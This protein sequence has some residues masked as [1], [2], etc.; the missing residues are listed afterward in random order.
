MKNTSQIE[1]IHMRPGISPSSPFPLYDL[2]EYLFQDLCRDLFDCEFGI[3]FCDVYGVRGQAQDGIDLIA[4]RKKA[5]EIEVGQCKCHKKFT[6]KQVKKASDEFFYHWKRWS[7]EG[8]KRFI[9]F[10]SCDLNDRECHDQILKEKKRFAEFGISYEA[11]SSSK[12][13]GKLGPHPAIVKR[14]FT[15][16]PDYWVSIICGIAPPAPPSSILSTQQASLILSAT[17]AQSERL[18]TALSTSAEKEI[19]RLREAWREGTKQEAS[20]WVNSI[21]NDSQVWMA[22]SENVR[23]KLLLFEA[24]LVLDEYGDLVQAKLLTEKARVLAPS[25]D[26]TRVLA[27]ITHRESGPKAAL[28]ILLG[29]DDLDSRNLKAAFLLEGGEIAQARSVLDAG[30]D[31]KPNAEAYR[32]RALS[33]VLLKDMVQARLEIQKALEIAPKWKGV[34]IAAGMI[35]Y[36]SALSPAIM[37]GGAVRW[38]EPVDWSFVKRDDASLLLL[39]DGEQFFRQLIKEAGD[40]EERRDFECWRLACFANDPDR[41]DDAIKFCRDILSRDKTHYRVISWAISRKYDVKLGPSEKRLKRLVDDNEAEIPHILSLV[42]IYLTS[43]PRRSPKAIKLLRDSESLFKKHKADHVWLFWFCQ[44]LVV[45]NDPSAAVEAIVGHEPGLAIYNIKAMALRSIALK[46][47]DF[48]P[49][50]DHLKNAYAKTDDPV[51]LH[52]SCELM[53]HLGDW[54]F[55]ADRA[56]ELA[57]RVQTTDA[58][59]LAG[60]SAYNAKRFHLC[61]RLLDNNRRLYSGNRLPSELRRVRANCCRAIGIIPEAIAEAESLA[62]EEPTTENLLDL[63]Y[64][65]S[66]KGD[67]KSLSIVARRILDRPD[68]KQEESLRLSYLVKWEDEALAIAL[69]RLATHLGIPDELV[70]AATDIGFQLGLDAELGPLSERMAFLGREGK[71]GIQFATIEDMISLVEKQREQSGKLNE[72]YR[73]GTAP[74]HVI[75]AQLNRPLVDY[76]HF[77]P[78][79]NQSSPDPA[80][81][82]SLM[83]RH[84]GRQIGEELPLV[85]GKSRICM[86]ITAVLLSM[87]LKILEQVERH[88]RPIAIPAEMVPALMDMREK[89][90]HH[91][92]KRLEACQQ[93]V[94]M[95][96]TGQIEALE[97]PLSNENQSLVKELGLEWLAIFEYARSKQGYLVDFYPVQKRG[98]IG[99]PASIPESVNEYVTNCRVLIES[100]RVEGPLSTEEH[101][102]ALSA[103]G[104]QGGIDI[105][106]GKIPKQGSLLILRANIPEIL[107]GANLL[108]TISSRFNVVV[109]KREFE[110]AKQEL[111]DNRKRSS[112]VNWLGALTDRLSHGIGEGTFDVLP[113]EPH[114]LLKESVEIMSVAFGCLRSLMRFS[115]KEDDIIWSDDRFINGYFRRDA[116]PIVGINEILQELRRKEVISSE[117]YYGLLLKLR[118][119]NARFIPVSKDEILHHLSHAVIRDGLVVETRALNILRRYIAACLHGGSM[120]QRPP[121]AEG[122]SNKTGELAFVLDLV[123]NVNDSVIES[124]KSRE[125]HE[126]ACRAKADWILDNLYFDHLGAIK[127]I[128]VHRAQEDE[129]YVVALGLVGL[130]SHAIGLSS[131][132]NLEARRNY[133]GWLSVRILKKRFDADPDLVIGVAECL[134][135]LIQE[136]RESAEK[137]GPPHVVA[138]LLQLY[139]DDLPHVIKDELAKDSAFMAAMDIRIIKINE[140]GGLKFNADEFWRH[141]SDVI[142]GRTGILSTVDSKL[143]VTFQPEEGVEE[144]GEFHFADPATG[145]KKAVKEALFSIMS[146]SPRVREMTLRKNKEWFDCPAE[147]FERA[148]GVIVTTSDVVQRIEETLHW[149][150]SSARVYYGKVRQRAAEHHEFK[151][152]EGLPP[153]GEGLLRHFRLHADLRPDVAFGEVIADAAH[154]LLHECGLLEAIDRLFGFPVALPAIMIDGVADLTLEEMHPAVVKLIRVAQ[155]PI[156]QIHLVHTLVRL[157]DKIPACRRIARQVA[158]NLLS[159]QGVEECEAFRALLRWTNDEFGY[160]HDARQWPAPVRLAMVWAHSHRLYCIFKSAGAPVSWIQEYFETAGRRLPAEIFE[161]HPDFRFDIAHPCQINKEILIL[162]GLAYGLG[163]AIEK[164]IDEKLGSLVLA[165]ASQEIEGKPVPNLNLL[166]DPRLAGD[167]LGSFLA[168]DRG[169]AFDTLLG[170]E[171]GQ[172][173]RSESLSS[174]LEGAFDRIMKGSEQTLAFDWAMVHSIIGDLPPP[175]DCVE[176]IKKCLYQIDLT[177]LFEKEPLFGG[178]LIQTM[179][180]QVGNLHDEDLHIYMKDQLFKIAKHLAKRLDNQLPNEGSDEKT[181]LGSSLLESALNLG[182]A[183]IPKDSAAAEFGKIVIQIIETWGE[184]AREYRP[185]IQRLCEELPLAYAKDLWPLLIRLRAEA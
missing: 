50:L 52:E 16:E 143:S 97:F 183:A 58:L 6:S 162:T 142:N 40:D 9:L 34:R 61:L 12:I 180:S 165:L 66:T 71:G 125:D 151:F 88:F 70:A 159:P 136:T 118:A 24:L 131:Y 117:C 170:S 41:Q 35:S 173:F 115:P 147:D 57:A 120:L 46:T 144:T 69:W 105:P 59:R 68:L 116:V 95:V 78:E 60:I 93:I 7:E 80:K 37:L 174:S 92:P 129:K 25:E 163:G 32:L 99:G 56:E 1:A 145:E 161:R 185:I 182:L 102:V 65:Y 109:E 176:R 17:L 169:V 127:T 14:Y 168:L 28:D 98:F 54:L 154:S 8:V 75:A 157:S 104:S 138:R 51:F 96:D 21:K 4:H 89:V 90:S 113:Q 20:D 22:L 64:M 123:R 84:G 27:F 172:T 42:G 167:C 10:V 141:I 114:P 108:S 11:W 39:R 18:A 149:R 53:A 166:R 63:A 47:K 67:L 82:F 62:K 86:D 126:D 139:Y 146:D 23:A 156:S 31:S 137:S 134:K 124:W 122:A 2:D 111:E 81:Q 3:A 45:N 38:P 121:M 171:V 128:L 91:Q 74:I 153:S 43:G 29:K 132:R 5:G 119:A 85:T 133:F 112:L 13:R 106:I 140:L 30:I 178:I 79:I 135:N 155:S 130:L 175:Q 148:V 181:K 177:G 77:F 150:D 103:L 73:N 152:N 83:I 76:Y 110:T 72:F 36:L 107:A 19:E 184:P 87:H 48:Q 26:Q 15:T 55:I 94:E 158:I 49:L 101:T 33:H 164:P 44:S 100:L 179:C 160:W